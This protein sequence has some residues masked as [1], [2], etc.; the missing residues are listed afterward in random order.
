MGAPCVLGD[1]EKWEV[2]M[3]Q[4]PTAPLRA[5]QSPHPPLGTPCPQCLIQPESF[6]S[7][8]IS[9]SVRTLGSIGGAGCGLPRDI[10]SE[11]LSPQVLRPTDCPGA[12]H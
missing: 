9:Q 5:T 7:V 4:Q 12:Y 10:L 2:V 6:T 8:P 3:V 11:A 1:S